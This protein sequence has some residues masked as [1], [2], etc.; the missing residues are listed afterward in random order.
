MNKNVAVFQRILARG[1][2]TI[3]RLEERIYQLRQLK[4]FA[5]EAEDVE[6]EYAYH[7][8]LQWLRAELKK[9]VAE[10]KAL[11]TLLRPEEK[12][13]GKSIYNTPEM[14]AWARNFDYEDYVR[15]QSAITPD[16]QKVS[17][18]GYQDLCAAFEDEM[19]RDAEFGEEI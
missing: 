17:E 11:K 9:Y 13:V 16:S 1:K 18:Q 2:Y 6:L 7:N 4:A 8:D 19:N 5:D 14:Q 15:L 12:P 3:T 10:Q